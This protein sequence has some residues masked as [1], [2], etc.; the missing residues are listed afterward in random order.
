MSR[1]LAW[2][3]FLVLMAVPPQ[4]MAGAA[5]RFDSIPVL[6]TD[7]SAPAPARQADV[8]ALEIDDD[9]DDGDDDDGSG[10][11][12]NDGLLP[13]E[14]QTALAARTGSLSPWSGRSSAWSWATQECGPPR[15]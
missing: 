11:A 5:L 4:A 15:A 6:S 7:H 1:A 2:L 9:G 10:P 3:S 14:V 8:E 12:L 13:N